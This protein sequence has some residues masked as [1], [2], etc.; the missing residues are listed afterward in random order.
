MKQ[1]RMASLAEAL[2][3]VLVGFV[4]ALLTQ[5]IIF[6]L[7]EMQPACLNTCPLPPSS[8]GCRCFGRML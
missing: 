2:T 1:S 8:R 4:V 6:P 5:L 7:F 3:N